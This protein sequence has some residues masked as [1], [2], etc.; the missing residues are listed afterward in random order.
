MTMGDAAG[1]EEWISASESYRKYRRGAQWLQKHKIRSRPDE[2][3]L[4]LYDRAAIEEMLAGGERAEPETE[5]NVGIAGN[6][7]ATEGLVKQV[8]L[9]HE[10]MFTAYDAANQAILKTLLAHNEA[11]N[12]H[13]IN[14]EDKGLELRVVLEGAISRQHEREI[15]E[16]ES[17]RRGRIQEQAV[18][19]I[20]QTLLPWLGPFLGK[21]L[22][23]D[24]PAPAAA[25][26]TSHAAQVGTFTIKILGSI[27]DEQFTGLASSLPKDI[28]DG[29]GELRRAILK[30]EIQ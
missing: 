18:Q 23:V 2:S 3:G 21:K 1:D 22:G 14:L 26:G 10:K 28:S 15:L 25:N 24:A 9:H 17:E 11:Q 30:G 20:G 16:K 5:V 13:I 19:Q 6:V 29:L 4:V 12:K 8:L 27:T 7:R